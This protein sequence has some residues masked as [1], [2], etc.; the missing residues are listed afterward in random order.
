MT[1]VYIMY[2]TKTETSMKPQLNKLK[3]CP[4]RSSRRS[5]SSGKSYT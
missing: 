2:R 1:G 3:T 5:R 4:V